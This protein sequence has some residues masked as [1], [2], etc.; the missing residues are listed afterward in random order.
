MYFF[1]KSKLEGH[2]ELGTTTVSGG[3][4]K[5]IASYIFEDIATNDKLIVEYAAG[6]SVPTLKL[7]Q[8]LSGVESTLATFAATSSDLNMNWEIRFLDE[9][10]TKFYYKTASGAKTKLFAGTV[11]ADL[12][13]CKVSYEYTTNEVT[14]RTIKS[15][16]FWNVYP[17][18]FISY[19][20]NPETQSKGNVRSWDTRGSETE[21]DWQRVFSADHRFIGDRIVENALIRL[22][23]YSTTEIKIYGWNPTNTA[24]EYT[25]SIIPMDTNGNLTTTL[26][27]VIFEQLSQSRTKM[28]AKM[29]VV[30]INIEMRRG[31]P[32][33][34]VAQN[35]KKVRWG[36]TKRR[37]CVSADYANDDLPD[38][39]QFMADEANTGNPL[40]LS[41]LS[42]QA[43]AFQNNAFQQINLT[44][45][46]PYTFS[47]DSNAT[48][49]LLNM[50]DNWI[51][52]FNENAASDVVGF[53]ACSKRPTGLIVKANSATE[54]D[55]LEITNDVKG[56]YGIGVLPSAPTTKISGIPKPFHIG[57]KDEYV[58]WRASESL[59]NI[60]QRSF[61]RKKR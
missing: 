50:D 30:D 25:S 8:V 46:N 23:F 37:F 22:R 56:V 15:D 1:P 40:N 19:D 55:Y 58:K 24:W 27:A 35:S 57:T 18:V 43:T 3:T 45:E 5:H 14:A 21:T 29:G 51:S 26:N 60:A 41:N 20:I 4:V 2:I 17:I 61:V 38:W 10:V 11:T 44:T 16:F 31:C 42:F 9:G 54:L 47:N 59:F 48:R 28:V 34:K 6:T 12:A 32:Y 7:K 33:I 39:N 13:E 49:G 52:V 36:T 53:F